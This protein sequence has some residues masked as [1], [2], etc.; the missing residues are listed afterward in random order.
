[1]NSPSLYRQALEIHPAYAAAWDGLAWVYCDLVDNYMRP[2]GEAIRLAREATQK[3]LAADPQ[4]ALAHARLGWIALYY[5]RDL[6]AAAE[7]IEHALAL[8]SANPDIIAIAA[9]LARRLGRLDQAIAISEYLRALDPVNVQGN[10]ELAT[11]YFY[12]GRLDA[13]IE[14]YRADLRL[15]PQSVADH[16]M[17]GEVLLLKGD[18]QAALVEMEKEPSEEARLNGLSMAYH[19]LGRHTES[20]TA[21]AELIKKYDRTMSWG[22]ACALAFRGEADRAFEWL[23]KAAQHNDLTVVSPGGYP[24]FVNLHSDPRWLPFLR[25]YG[26]A[27]EQLAAIKFDVKVPK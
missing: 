16:E 14:T 26:M 4:Y 22:I 17:I 24:L 10:Y 8:E 1:L 3:A 25:K 20:D 21:L 23:N 13:A 15:F 7:H 19:A 6:V 2:A 18:A 11:A 9:G 27:P 12:A 5:D